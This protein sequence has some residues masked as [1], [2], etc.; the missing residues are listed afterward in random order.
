LGIEWGFAI[1]FAQI[2]KNRRQRESEDSARRRRSLIMV[3]PGQTGVRY[4]SS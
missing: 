1:G 3:H 2:P 4:P